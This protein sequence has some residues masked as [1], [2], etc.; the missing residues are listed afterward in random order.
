MSNDAYAQAVRMARVGHRV[1][2]LRG[3]APATSNGFHGASNDAQQ[4]EVWG[5]GFPE[6]NWGL[7]TDNF[8]V[9]DADAQWLAD[10]LADA[11]PEAPRVR[12]GKG[13]HFYFAGDPAVGRTV[14]PGGRPKTDR[15]GVLLEAEWLPLDSCSGPTG[16]V[17]LPGSV[18][19]D[20]GDRY[21]L[22]GGALDGPLPPLPAALAAIATKELFAGGRAAKGTALRRHLAEAPGGPGSGRNDW[23]TAL[24]GHL[25]G[26][27]RA[28]PV[29]K[30]LYDAVIGHFCAQ[31][32]PHDW[33]EA[34]WTDIGERIW[35]KETEKP[36]GTDGGGGG[37]GPSV[38]TVLVDILDAGYRAVRSEDD[39]A[40]V[41][42]P[43]D[44]GAVLDVKSVSLSDSLA[45]AAYDQTGKVPSASAVNEALGVW[46]GRNVGA[47]SERVF[48]RV[49]S[50]PEGWA[51][52]DLCND[53]GEV[54]VI[55]PGTWE[56][57][58]DSP[59]L[60]RRPNG[61]LPLP[62]PLPGTG[63]VYAGRELHNVS[64]ET[65]RLLR[66]WQSAALREDIPH[67]IAAVTGQPGSA[68]TTLTRL[69]TQLIDP[70]VAKD[71]VVPPEKDWVQVL[72]SSWC[73]AFDNVS[74]LADWTSDA[75]CKA[76]TGDGRRGRTLF[77]DSDTN[78]QRIRRVIAFNGL[79][80][81]GVR[82]DLA[83][84]SMLVESLPVTTRLE[85]REV[86]ERA[87]AA[88]AKA[89]A[90]VLDLTADALA[91]LPDVRLENAPR[92][93][94]FARHLA[95][96]DKA[97]EWDTL[98]EFSGTRSSISAA[99]LE[100]SALAAALLEVVG[101]REGRWGTSELHN[102]LSGTRHMSGKAM[103]P[104][105]AL[106]SEINA[107]APLMKEVWGIEATHVKG[108][109]GNG[110]EFRR[111]LVEAVEVPQLVPDFQGE[112]EGYPSFLSPGAPAEVTEPPQPPQPPHLSRDQR[113]ALLAHV[114]KEHRRLLARQRVGQPSGEG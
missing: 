43:V 74:R 15:D 33:D 83:D 71:I 108:R 58:A 29:H 46:R 102:R 110:F 4:V 8:T 48:V 105:N 77:T 76:A 39:A 59:V 94:D 56:V 17:V 70:H 9:I 82:G 92:M 7:V 100:T 14:R 91:C 90:G 64:D 24:A 99:I 5:R 112:T 35:V 63:D 38:A 2:P 97:R 36:G 3:K 13:G 32:D 72:R 113:D 66:A 93:A 103:P 78:E 85:D 23:A 67:A 87:A 60:F 30:W 37:R 53:R 65:F 57:T 28:D 62:T 10:A 88:A 31:L 68:K 86:S 40:L 54:V 114:L 96:I 107:L 81:A 12:T 1:F 75:L 111:L 47:P 41:A 61:S 21:E 106:T 50:T 44:G 22:A 20:T 84:R 104:L 73:A 51:V 55:R 42:V 25:A 18:H 27:L 98:K 26:L 69:L 34:T 49:G 95:A 19:P 6:A 80:L 45:A 11:F 101:F 89:L 79:G 52:L 16:Y 109:K